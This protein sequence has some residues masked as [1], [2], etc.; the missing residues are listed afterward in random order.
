MAISTLP[1]IIYFFLYSR[2]FLTGH[3]LADLCPVVVFLGVMSSLAR[4]LLWLLSSLLFSP[5]RLSSPNSEQT[6]ALDT[7]S[8]SIVRLVSFPNVC[9]LPCRTA[10][11]LNP[12][13]GH[14]LL[15]RALLPQK[16]FTGHHSAHTIVLTRLPMVKEAYM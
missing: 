6:Q 16:L 2:L 5:G 14:D 1:F 15:L 3:S 8:L 13:V 11:P 10:G 12:T 9:Q 4:G 7:S